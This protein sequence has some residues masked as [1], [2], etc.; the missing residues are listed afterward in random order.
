MS[1]TLPENTTAPETPGT[2]PAKTKIDKWYLLPIGAA[3]CAAFLLGM[4]TGSN[5]GNIKDCQ[6][7]VAMA[8]EAVDIAGQA[9]VYSGDAVEA[10]TRFDPDA[11]SR[12]GD[13]L[14]S[15]KSGQLDPLVEPYEA[16]KD[17]CMG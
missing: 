4:L 9:L 8:E 13:D 14:Q 7:A 2:P 17:K 11:L 15:L 1:T 6:E 10:A 16:A 12:A 5:S 3:V